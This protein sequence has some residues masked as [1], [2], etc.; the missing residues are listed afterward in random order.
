MDHGK[1]MNLETSIS[2]PYKLRT[3][4]RAGDLATAKSPRYT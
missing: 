2:L 4:T 3:E 1:G